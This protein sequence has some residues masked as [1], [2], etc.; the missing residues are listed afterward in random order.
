MRRR[1]TS[2]FAALL[3]AAALPA[4]F[5]TA[6]CG[7]TPR[8][9]GH[10][11]QV[12]PLPSW[13]DTASRRA[14][15][16][17]VRRVTTPGSPDFV[18][19]P[20]R[21]AVFDNDGTLWCEQPEYPQVAFM[22]ERIRALAPQHPEWSGQ[23]P[24]KSLIA[25]DSSRAFASGPDAFKVLLEATHGGVTTD[26]FR[27]MSRAWIERSRNAAGGR[28]Y[29]EMVYR[30]M[31]ELL[32]Y[33]RASGFKTFIVSGGDTEFMRVFAEEVYGVPPEQV[34][35]TSLKME[36]QVGDA[37]P[38]IFRRRALEYGNDRAEKVV[39]IQR[40]IGRRP[41]AAF[42]NSD[43]DYA[44]IEWTTA[45]DG[46]RLG[47]FVHHTD[48]EREWAYDRGS[49]IGKLEKGLDAAAARG[50]ILIDMKRDWHVIFP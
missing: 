1:L 27:A 28:P 31:I 29:T 13:N 22:I 2:L 17:F 48:A 34:I 11:C 15:V 5:V 38:V 4:L 35:G 25:G 3:L 30:P 47:A 42:G 36:Y 46:A 41:I 40:Q 12:D 9:A 14:I 37:G 23:E 21:I 24:Y 7:A 33:F 26:E 49:R 50:W 32:S 19:P 10:A 39:S 45:G 16:D 20:E 44:M 18:A 8:A 43:G 6:G